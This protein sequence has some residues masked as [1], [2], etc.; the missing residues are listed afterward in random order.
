MNTGRNSKSSDSKSSRSEAGHRKLARWAVG[1]AALIIA[2]A[3]VF[4]LARFV[5]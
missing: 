4:L 3:I 1:L 2:I 5:G